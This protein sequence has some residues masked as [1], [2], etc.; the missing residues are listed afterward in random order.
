MLSSFYWN[1]FKWTEK[2]T[3]SGKGYITLHSYT[4]SDIFP[5]FKMFRKNDRQATLGA[6]KA[7]G[8]FYTL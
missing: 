1:I 2:Q 4:V 6:E 8:R 5:Y 3:L 7:P